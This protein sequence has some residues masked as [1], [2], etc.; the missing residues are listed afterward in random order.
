MFEDLIPES[1]K[2]PK[3][4]KSYERCPYCN[5]DSIDSTDGLFIP[6]GYVE[7]VVCKICGFKWLVTYDV[8]LNVVKIQH[9]S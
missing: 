2:I 6:N 3:E 7:T 4:L 5:S 8:D 1:K 9:G